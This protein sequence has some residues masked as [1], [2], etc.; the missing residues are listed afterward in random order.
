MRCVQQWAIE[1]KQEAFS[2]GFEHRPDPSLIRTQRGLCVISGDDVIN[3]VRIST[4]ACNLDEANRTET[5][6]LTMGG[7][8]A[9]DPSSIYR[10]VLA[11]KVLKVDGF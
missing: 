6:L 7:G 1:E 10:R 5:M 2:F 11:H 8:R 4:S 9:G 3:V